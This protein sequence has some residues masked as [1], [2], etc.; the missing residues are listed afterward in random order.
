METPNEHIPRLYYRAKLAKSGVVRGHLLLRSSQQSAWWVFRLFLH[1]KEG[2]PFLQPVRKLLIAELVWVRT[3][4]ALMF[5]P[6]RQR[7]VCQYMPHHMN[8]FRRWQYLHDNSLTVTNNTTI[9]FLLLLFTS[10][11]VSFKICKHILYKKNK[12]ILISESKYRWPSCPK[13]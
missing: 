4:V 2:P 12:H 3:V 6:H 5:W 10:I 7:N 11:K 1:M 13:L 8:H 9:F